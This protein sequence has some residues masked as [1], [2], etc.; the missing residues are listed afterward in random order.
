VPDNFYRVENAEHSADDL[1]GAN[2]VESALAAHRKKIEPWLSAIFQSE[3]LNLLI[4]SGFSMGLALAAG[5]APLSMDRIQID[6]AFDA[7]INAAS[8]RDALAMGR[9]QAN[10][11][12]QFRSAIALS[13]GLAVQGDGRHAAFSTNLSMALASFGMG[14]V[15]MEQRI[16]AAEAARIERFEHLLTGFLMSFASRTAS[17]DRLHIFTTNYD[18]L[19][20]HGFDLIGARP[21]DRFVGA[22]NPRFRA[23]RF[24]V[25]IHY[26]PPGGRGDARPLEGVVRLT[27]LHGSVDWAS[28]NRQIIRRAMPFG[29]PHVFGPHEGD[30]LLIFPNS[31]KDIETAFFPYAE[32]FRDFSAAIC[33]PNSALV[34]YGYGFGDDHVNRV[35]RDML[36]LPS[37][38]LVVI[39]YD[40]AAGRIQRFIQQCGRSAQ[41]SVII[42]PE[43]A[44]LDRLVEHFLP[45]PAIDT[46][47]QRQAEILERRG[48]D[49]AGEDHP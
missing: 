18:R 7:Q 17:R 27:K 12:D 31:A 25:D 23:S 11:E 19:I 13:A 5:Q 32:L 43:I 14:I 29:G 10:V 20:E 21:I 49:R 34:T 9:G 40:R 3:H 36:S 41:V 48:R 45:K 35:L 28:V 2:P 42:G 1:V 37:T 8:D 16:A 4:G 24:D 33:R 44:G 47:T 39:S 6:P 22:L 15:G 26:S 38:H 30:D 46:I